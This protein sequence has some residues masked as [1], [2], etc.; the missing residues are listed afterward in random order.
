[1]GG[2]DARAPARRVL[3]VVDLCGGARG[4]NQSRRISGGIIIGGGAGVWIAVD[5]ERHNKRDLRMRGASR[6]DWR[7]PKY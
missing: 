1:M 6:D 7:H 3:M 4:G 2:A 5:L